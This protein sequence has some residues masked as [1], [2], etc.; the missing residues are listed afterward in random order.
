MTPAPVAPTQPVSWLSGPLGT[1]TWRM[2]ATVLGGQGLSILLGAA[3]ARSLSA[4]SGEGNSQ[5]RLWS[6]IGLGLLCFAAAGGMRRGWGL[7]LGWLAQA[8]T[9]VSAI[10][11][12]M[13]MWVAALFLAMWLACLRKGIQID[14]GQLSARRA[15]R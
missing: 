9:L 14:T 15:A 11:V 2:L 8:L 5:L 10:F 13:M 3:L 7:Q 1:F 6:M 4:T 12:P